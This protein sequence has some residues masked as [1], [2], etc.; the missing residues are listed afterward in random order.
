MHIRE[1]NTNTD[2]I[3]DD[4]NFT[5]TIKA[6]DKIAMYDECEEAFSS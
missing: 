5:D 3:K 1:L 4:N 6:A 2:Y